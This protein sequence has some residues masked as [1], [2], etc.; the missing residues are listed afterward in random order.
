MGLLGYLVLNGDG[1]SVG[2]IFWICW[3]VESGWIWV[4]MEFVDKMEMII[5]GELK[6]CRVRVEDGEMDGRGGME[7]GWG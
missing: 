6:C 7:W 4:W 2:D 1:Y 3:L 5:G